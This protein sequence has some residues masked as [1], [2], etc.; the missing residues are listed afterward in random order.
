MGNHGIFILRIVQF[1]LLQKMPKSPSNDL[2]DLIKSLSKAEK[3]AFKI[4]VRGNRVQ[5]T[6]YFKLFNLVE[7]G[8]VYDEKKIILTLKINPLRFPETKH[9]LY[10]LLLK[11]LNDF[12]SNDSVKYRLRNALNII[13][14][15][16]QK[17]LYVQ[18]QKQIT[19]AVAIAKKFELNFFL[20]ELIECQLDVF[21]ATQYVR[22]EKNK[23]EEQSQQIE[24]LLR[25][26]K[27]ENDYRTV[28]KIAY[29]RAYK[30]GGFRSKDESEI[31]TQLHN[32]SKSCLPF[33]TMLTYYSFLYRYYSDMRHYKKCVDVMKK[34]LLL[35]EANPHQIPERPLSYVA[36]ISNIIISLFHLKKFA[37]IPAYI[38]KL[39]EAK[40]PTIAVNNFILTKVI[41]FEIQYYIQ[42]GNVKSGM[43]ALDK[44]EDLIVKK[45]TQ[46]LQTE[47]L[48]YFDSVIVCIQAV[49]YKRANYFLRKIFYGNYSGIRVDVFCF[50]KV[51]ALIVNFELKDHDHLAYSVKSVYRYLSKNKRLYKFE[52]IILNFIQKKIL[53]IVDEKKL[54]EAFKNLRTELLKLNND[55]FE[56]EV[57]EHFD[58]ISWLDSKIENRNFAEIVREKANATD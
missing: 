6:M 45:K 51:L 9:Y 8:K 38:K 54:K 53:K 19:K 30:L 21:S 24:K 16:L 58:F 12:H 25:L 3:A 20:I 57:F 50:A 5:H 10:N 47:L 33:D 48:L 43:P 22:V 11:I 52:S 44:L 37:E 36:A 17:G 40:A 56:K 39:S 32:R 41:S 26:L 31:I 42:T 49:D 4:Y 1:T 27:I 55:P 18:C 15:L 7:K 2:F 28:T 29:L 14:I 13:N 34:A 23:I 35:I 46:S